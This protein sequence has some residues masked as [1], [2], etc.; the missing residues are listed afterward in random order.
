MLFR[1]GVQVT[2]AVQSLDVVRFQAAGL[3]DLYEQL[4]RSLAARA[5]RDL[6]CP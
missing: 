4:G 3:G 2:L 1:S 6:D 5:D